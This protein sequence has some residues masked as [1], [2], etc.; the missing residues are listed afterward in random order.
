MTNTMIRE[1]LGRV[2]GLPPSAVRAYH[3]LS[4]HNPILLED[5]TR[6]FKNYSGEYPKRDASRP[7]D[8]A[9]D[10]EML[11]GGFID[12]IYPELACCKVVAQ[13]EDNLDEIC[14]DPELILEY[15]RTRMGCKK[16]T[17][18]LCYRQ[19]SQDSDLP[20][21]WIIC[22]QSLICPEC[23]EK[24]DKPY[25]HMRGGCF[26]GD[27]PDPR[28]ETVVRQQNDGQNNTVSNIQLSKTYKNEG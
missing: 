22:L 25:P 27:K 14:D 4:N 18:E 1:R 12:Q 7:V 9:P 26:A 11:P 8:F 19:T 15:R 28:A 20:A 6:L 16:W 24:A 21:G 5:A 3:D 17:C 23:Q 13:A 2:D 10:T